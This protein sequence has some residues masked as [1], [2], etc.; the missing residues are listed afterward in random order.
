MQ[1]YNFDS[2]KFRSR[3]GL[4]CAPFQYFPDSV[5]TQTGK[6]LDLPYGEFVLMS[7]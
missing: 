1:V 5:F 6:G 4:C 3:Q 2:R 7:G